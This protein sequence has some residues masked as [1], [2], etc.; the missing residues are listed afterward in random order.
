MIVKVGLLAILQPSHGITTNSDEG[1]NQNKGG[2]SIYD[3]WSL[4]FGGNQKWV[5]E[6]PL[7]FVSCFD[8]RTILNTK[9][10][11][12][13]TLIEQKYRDSFVTLFQSSKILIVPKKIKELFATYC[14]VQ[15]P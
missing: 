12:S 1:E 8:K 11:G 6:I 2:K 13:L 15:G 3:K 4:N 5:L 7:F 14:E 10:H 9:F